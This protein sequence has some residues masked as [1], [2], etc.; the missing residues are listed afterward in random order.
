MK[1]IEVKE[2]FIIDSEKNGVNDGIASD[3]KR[4]SLLFNRSQNKLLTLQLQNRKSDDVR[5]IQNF[6]VLDKSIPTTSKFQDKINFILPE[7]Y[8]DLADARAR[9][10]K[11]NCTDLIYLFELRTENLS[12][13]LQDEFNKPSFEWREA[14]YTVNSN[15]FSI[16]TNNEFTITELLLNYYRYPNQ[17]TLLQEDN[18]ESDFD[19]TLKMEWDDKSLDDIISLMVFNNDINE[20]NPRYQL[21]T[22]KIQK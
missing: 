1:W 3:N 4:V 11:Q 17:M 18:A 12:E 5:Y 16:Y 9:A 14:P 20:N 7:N 10:K 2:R 22:M 15:S 21:Q 8:F 19:E 6:L 13:V